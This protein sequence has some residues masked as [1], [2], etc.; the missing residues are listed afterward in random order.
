MRQTHIIECDGRTFETVTVM[1]AGFHGA[2][3]GV[4]IYEVVRPNWKFFRTDRKSVV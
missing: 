1:E 4:H 3:A 2:M